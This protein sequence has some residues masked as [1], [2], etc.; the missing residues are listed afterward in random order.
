MPQDYEVS[1]PYCDR[2]NGAMVAEKTISCRW[3]SREFAIAYLPET[4]AILEE[5][6]E[7]RNKVT[8]NENI[9]PSVANALNETLARINASPEVSVSLEPVRLVPI[10]KVNEVAEIDRES[11]TSFGAFTLFLG[12]IIEG[13]LSRQADMPR[14]FLL[15]V[16]TTM[17]GVAAFHF[18]QKAKH[19]REEIFQLAEK[20]STRVKLIMQASDANDRQYS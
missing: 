7:L 18:Y 5:L 3:C 14:L 20:N 16:F 10:N 6:Q 13:L 11:G 2:K 15:V 1:C 4:S 17:A 8:A 12:L 9:D 19:K